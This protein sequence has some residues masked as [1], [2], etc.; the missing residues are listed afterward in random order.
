[1]R[2]CREEGGMRPHLLNNINCALCRH[3]SNDNIQ[4][5]RRGPANWPILAE[6]WTV[7]F[8]FIL[9]FFESRSK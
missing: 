4:N 9:L 5:G 1:M 6:S 2:V 3:H 8:C 7:F